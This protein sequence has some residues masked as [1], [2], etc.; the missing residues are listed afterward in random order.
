MK[1]ICTLLLFV[2]LFLSTL[3]SQAQI[4]AGK[5]KARFELALGVGVLPTF[6]QDNTTQEQIPLS[7]ELRYRPSDVFTIGLLAGRTVASTTLRHH[8]G[9]QQFVRND[10][11]LMALRA[12]VNSRRWDRAEVYGGILL[13][14]QNGKISMDNPQK[15]G[16]EQLPVFFR[17]RPQH[18]FGTAY[19]GGAWEPLPRVKCFAELSY[20]LSLVTVGVAYGW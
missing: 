4:C 18:F 2:G 17:P 9:V 20:G 6:L 5:G 13:G 16:A 7:L 1:T 11:R 8:S 14:Y 15:A 3:P 10:Y 12:G 19:L